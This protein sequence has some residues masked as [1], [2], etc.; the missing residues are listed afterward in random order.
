MGC[1][2]REIRE[3]QQELGDIWEVIKFSFFGGGRRKLW[4]EKPGNLTTRPSA[5]NL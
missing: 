1:E 2:R 3:R 5:Y 4:E